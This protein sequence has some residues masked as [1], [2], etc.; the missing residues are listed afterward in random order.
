MIDLAAL[1]GLPISE[2]RVMAAQYGISVHHKAKAETIV[3]LIVDAVAA[4]QRNM[5]QKK[6]ERVMEKV[7]I[8]SEE[9]VRELIEPWA[10]KDGFK[11]TFHGDDTVTFS[12]K[13]AEESV[14]LSAREK[15]IRT[16]AEIVAR[17]ARNPRM[18]TLDGER[19][20]SV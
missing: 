19:M 20:L 4:Q 9:R 14:H 13:G 3:G 2:L 18:M 6:G 17:G 10:S 5:Q 8:C 16:R 7:V 1:R 15:V 11:V 12:Y